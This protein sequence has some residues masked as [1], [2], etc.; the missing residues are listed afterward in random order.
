MIVNLFEEVSSTT[1]EG[2]LPFGLTD[3]YS[4]DVCWEVD[5]SML[6]WV[7][8]MYFRCEVMRTRALQPERGAV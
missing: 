4:K 3:R 7:R 6:W 8:G 2:T 1:S 5:K